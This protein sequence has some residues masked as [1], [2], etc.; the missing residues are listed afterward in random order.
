[1]N[2]PLAVAGWTVL[3]ALAGAGVRAGT[4]ALTRLEE[5]TPGRERWQAFGPPAL[6][7]ILFGA[8]AWH[9]G[10]GWPLVVRSVWIAVMV[11]VV[12]FDLE[13]RLILDRVLLP[14]SVLALALSFV[15]GLGPGW[16]SSLLAAVLA[17]GLL[18]V[19]AVVGALIF[20]A[21]ALGLGD[22]KFAAFM[23]LV[24]GLRP[25]YFATAAALIYGVILGGAGALAVVLLR[26]STKG[27][28]AYGPYLAG[29]ALVALFVMPVR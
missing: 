25:P 7:A 1:M 9:L 8:F 17:G 26:R 6:T 4:V 14:A 29:G 10:V 16:K 22:V 2:G 27:Y 12:F 11:H 15:P 5:L 28:F 13:H 23:G 24:L 18:L 21:E 19:L 20:R 3:G